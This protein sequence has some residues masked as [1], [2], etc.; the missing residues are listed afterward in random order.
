MADA[1]ETRANF[2]AIIM[3]MI[4]IQVITKEIKDSSKTHVEGTIR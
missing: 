2:K 3:V 4:I 1:N